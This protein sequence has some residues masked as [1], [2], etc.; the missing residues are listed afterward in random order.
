[1]NENF[2]SALKRGSVLT[3]TAKNPQNQDLVIGINLAG[4][5]AVYDR[6]D[7][8]TIEEYQQQV[9]GAASL[10]Q[11]LQDRAEAERRRLEQA[12]QPPATPPPSPQ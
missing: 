1:V 10:Q 4:F 8:P 3:L 6:Q 5:T 12:N 9:T 11:M 7:A 2:I